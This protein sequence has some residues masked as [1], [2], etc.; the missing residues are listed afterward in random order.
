ME[1][2]VVA[3]INGGGPVIRIKT[4]NGDIKLSKAAG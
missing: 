1:N 2:I 4:F 3:N